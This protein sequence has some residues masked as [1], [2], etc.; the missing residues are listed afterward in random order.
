MPDYQKALIAQIRHELGATDGREIADN[1]ILAVINTKLTSQNKQER[2]TWEEIGDRV[3][4]QQIAD[5]QAYAQAEIDFKPAPQEKFE[6]KKTKIAQTANTGQKVEQKMKTSGPW[7]KFGRGKGTAYGE[8]KINFGKKNEGIFGEN[9]TNIAHFNESTK[10]DDKNDRAR[11]VRDRYGLANGEIIPP[12]KMKMMEQVLIKQVTAIQDVSVRR[13]GGSISDKNGFSFVQSINAAKYETIGTSRP[14][15]NLQIEGLSGGERFSVD[16]SEKPESQL[17]KLTE[18]LNKITLEKVA[19]IESGKHQKARI[20]AAL[21]IAKNEANEELD[22]SKPT[23]YDKNVT[24][25]LNWGVQDWKNKSFDEIKNQIQGGDKWDVKSEST[26]KDYFL[27]MQEYAKKLRQKQSATYRAE[28]IS[29]TIDTFYPAHTQDTVK[30][31]GRASLGEISEKVHPANIRFEEFRNA[32]PNFPPAYLHI[33]Y[34]L[35]GEGVFEPNPQGRSLLQ[36]VNKMITPQELYAL[37]D[38]TNAQNKSIYD[39]KTTETTDLLKKITPEK[40][41]EIFAH[42]K[43]RAEQGFNGSEAEEL[44]GLKLRLDGKGGYQKIGKKELYEGIDLEPLA[45]ENVADLFESAKNQAGNDLTQDEKNKI[46]ASLLEKFSQLQIGEYDDLTD[47]KLKKIIDGMGLKTLIIKNSQESEDDYL[48][49]LKTYIKSIAEF[50]FYNPEKSFKLYVKDKNLT[51]NNSK[52]LQTFL[53]FLEEWH[54]TVEE[55]EN[56]E[57]AKIVK[58]YLKY[59]TKEEAVDIYVKA[60]LCKREQKKFSNE[61]I[62]DLITESSSTIKEFNENLDK[63]NKL[64][65]LIKKIYEYKHI[66][67]AVTVYDQALLHLEPGTQMVQEIMQATGLSLEKACQVVYRIAEKRNKAVEQ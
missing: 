56:D 2:R 11:R 23:D 67:I 16:F 35:M 1:Q 62:I 25:F 29:Q 15:V 60:D 17:N 14:K 5:L 13:H 26:N 7:Y 44:A 34:V 50:T 3:T 27:K 55:D 51:P 61:L 65:D 63:K 36:R 46:I 21:I 19:E 20:D 59:T 40:I 48:S 42:I 43:T 54:S 41:K 28:R 45:K 37:L 9:Y 32:N 31:L 12:Q 57:V 4:K 47:D 58:D 52:S 33:A 6:S 8:V 49:R 24:N 10:L 38:A 53:D 39:L 66:D 30:L 64:K 18:F 22:T